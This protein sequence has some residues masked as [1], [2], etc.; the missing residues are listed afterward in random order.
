MRYINLLLISFILACSTDNQQKV[1]RRVPVRLA[2]VEHEFISIPLNTSGILS[3]ASELKLSFKTGGIIQEI[4]VDIGQQ[5]HK[6]QIL[7]KLDLAEMEAN[8]TQAASGLEKAKRDAERATHLY[9]D[10]A[11]TLEQFQNVQTA[12]QIAKANARIADFNLKHSKIV[13]PEKGVILHKRA[14][15]GELISPGMPVFYFGSQGKEWK[16]K[17]GLTAGDVL[18]L[19]IGDAAEIKFDEYPDD[20]F[21][22][23]ITQIGSGAGSR[24]GLY[25]VELSLDANRHKLLSGLFGTA[26]ILPSTQQNMQ[27]IPVAALVEAHGDDGIVFILQDSSVKKLK[28]KI[29]HILSDKVAISNGLENVSEVISLG[30]AYLEEGVKVKVVADGK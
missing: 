1:E 28:V 4:M 16:L 27:L 12:L 20:I 15:P 18:K 5:V 7:A 9:K 29:A 11:I 21:S 26:E 8:A 2:P 17:T 13:A 10:T 14:E 22:A 6:G 23:R 24:T 25:E 3:A 19:Q 30:A